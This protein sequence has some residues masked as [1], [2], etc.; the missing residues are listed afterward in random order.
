M[1]RTTR[2]DL[3]RQIE[4]MAKALDEKEAECAD[5]R[6]EYEIV[7]LQLASLKLNPPIMV[8]PRCGREHVTHF[9]HRWRRRFWLFLK[10][11]GSP[12]IRRNF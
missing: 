3:R 2:G 7:S 10:S 1:A 9:S 8:A 5:L 4:F 12:K 11:I 6:H